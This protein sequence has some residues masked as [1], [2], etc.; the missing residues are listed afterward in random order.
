M[1]TLKEI[2]LSII[3]H[4]KCEDLELE[5]FLPIYD[6]YWSSIRQK[7]IKLLEIGIGK[8]GSLKIW[9]EYFPNGQIFGADLLKDK[10]YH[11]DRITTFYLNQDDISSIENAKKFGPYDIIIDDGGHM[12]HQQINTLITLFDSV[13]NGG[14]YIVEDTGTSYWPHFGG[15]YPPKKT[16]TMEVLKWL[17]DS[18]NSIFISYSNYGANKNTREVPNFPIYN[19]ESI[20]FYQ[21]V[22]ILCKQ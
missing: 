13:K 20:H 9:K 21:G 4:S 5:D 6:K 12:M 16:T 15:E 11:E 3:G 7:E 10:L 19:I 1:K 18:L 2:G 17:C 8:G 14:Q 22:V